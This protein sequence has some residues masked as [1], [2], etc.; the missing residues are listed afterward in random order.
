LLDRHGV[1]AA[2]LQVSRH[3]VGDHVVVLDDQHARHGAYD[4]S[5]LSKSR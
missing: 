1:E 4:R 2:R 5:G 3:A